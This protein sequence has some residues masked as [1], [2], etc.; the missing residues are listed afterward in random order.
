MHWELLDATG[1][2][3][4]GRAFHTS[5]L[6]DDTKLIIFGGIGVQGNMNT[7]YELDLIAKQWNVIFTT[8][9]NPGDIPSPR[10]GHSLCDTPHDGTCVLFGGAGA[11]FYNDLF[12]FDA[13][14]GRWTM[15]LPRGN[16]PAPRAFHTA[17]SLVH[18]TKVFIFGGQ[19]G[20]STHN[21]LHEL[22]LESLTWTFVRTRGIQPAPRWGHATVAVGMDLMLSFGGA[23]ESFMNDLIMFNSFKHTWSYVHGLGSPPSARWGHSMVL[24]REQAR[25]VITCGCCKGSP[26][27]GDGHLFNMNALQRGPPAPS[28]AEA[29]SGESNSAQAAQNAALRDL[30]TIRDDKPTWQGPPKDALVRRWSAPRIRVTRIVRERAEA[31]VKEQVNKVLEESRARA[32]RT[33]GTR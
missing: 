33:S 20:S 32:L 6:I 31:A 5:H 25:V 16:K 17:C 26:F 3:P 10:H 29:S 15:L 18:N 21:D 22:D 12:L 9:A 7:A 14:T 8:G 1:S 19:N 30:L 2:K 13:R 28:Q 4:P 27:M 23:G 11:G 24:Q